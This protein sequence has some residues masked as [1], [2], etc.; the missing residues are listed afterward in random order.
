MIMTPVP[1]LLDTLRQATRHSHQQLDRHPVLA[2]LPRPSLNLTQYGHALAALHGVHAAMEASL[3][4][5]PPWPD[6]AQCFPPRRAAL[7]QDLAELGIIPPPLTLALPPLH[8]VGA[9]LGR[10]YVLEGSAL[11]GKMIALQIQRH[12]LAAPLR[13]FS[14]ATSPERWP[15]LRERA[16]RLPASE[17]PHAIAAA[18][19]TFA[20]YHRHLDTCVPQAR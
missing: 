4:A 8:N 17:A 15:C 9:W 3:E 20:L 14:C 13:F 18:Q 2:C 7:A 6:F 1:T 19:H 11:G 5:Q 16:S 12:G 10:L